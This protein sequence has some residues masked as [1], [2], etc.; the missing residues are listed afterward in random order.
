M[1]Q[2]FVFLFLIS[3]SACS[4]KRPTIT[5]GFEGKLMPSFDLLLMD[6]TTHLNTNNIPPGKPVVLFYFSPFCPYC[7][8][9]TKSIISEIS[10]VKDIRFYFFSNFPFENVK[11]YYKGYSFEK[12]SNITVAADYNNYFGP[13]F[14]TP[15]VPYIA[16]YDKNKKLKQAMIGQVDVNIIRGLAFE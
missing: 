9:Q 15:G 7:K 8:A 10:K 11:N 16:I 6:S 5:T 1:K 2:T 4:E 14:N 12:C 13:Y 3:L